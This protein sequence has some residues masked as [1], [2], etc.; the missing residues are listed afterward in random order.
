MSLGSNMFATGFADTELQRI[1]LSSMQDHPLAEDLS[2][3]NN[4][5][6]IWSPRSVVWSTPLV[7]PFS[8]SSYP[9]PNLGAAYAPL[10]LKSVFPPHPDKNH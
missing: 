7:I 8:L 1:I 6:T 9:S 3:V 5:L 10:I 2:V 4:T